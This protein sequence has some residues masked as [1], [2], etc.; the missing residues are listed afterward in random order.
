MVKFNVL[1]HQLVP[2]HMILAVEEITKLL[3]NYNITKNQLPKIFLKDPCVKAIG[4]KV[5]DVINIV[6]ESPT[7]GTSI[8]Y[9]V[10]IEG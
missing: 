5:G 7:A 8:G 6:R 1:R 9:R 3:E 10:V 2:N 4:A